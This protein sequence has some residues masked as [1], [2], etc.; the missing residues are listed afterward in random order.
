[1]PW[2]K[3]TD[4]EGGGKNILEPGEYFFKVLPSVEF[5]E[6]Y[7]VHTQADTSSNGNEQIILAL[8][9]GT[10][11]E[12][13]KMV[14]YLTFTEGAAWRIS[15]FIKAVG[16]YPGSSKDVELT[17]AKCIGLTGKCETAVEKNKK[18]YDRMR[19]AWY[20]PADKQDPNLFVQPIEE[21]DIP[22]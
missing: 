20:I 19:I 4:S 17:A 2:V 8:E 7:T 12:R 15:T 3:T 14:D 9:V 22:F 10:K 13:V 16:G 1:M 5:S 21:D 18:G 6:S 11:D